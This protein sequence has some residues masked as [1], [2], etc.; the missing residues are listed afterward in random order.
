MIS[1]EEIEAVQ[2]AWADGIVKIGKAFVDGG[3]YKA[4]A[5]AHVDTLYAY[6][7]E[8]V[9]FKPTRAAAVPFRNTREDALS[10]FVGGHIDE[11]TGFAINPWTAVRFDNNDMVRSIGTAIAMGHYYFTAP[12]GQVVKVEYTFGYRRDETG[13]LR[14]VLQHS[15][16]P[17]S[18]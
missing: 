13:A 3:D 15:S 4:L 17:F 10:Y 1:R 16:I 8:P 14:I 5:E 6:G 12:D 18:A 11:D 9:L 7:R 2:Q